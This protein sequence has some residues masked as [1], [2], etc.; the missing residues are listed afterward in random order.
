MAALSTNQYTRVYSDGQCERV[1]LYAVKKASAGDTA[2]VSADFS[3]VIRAGYVSMAGT[4]I[5][6]CTV[7]SNTILTIPTGPANDA[8]VMVVVGVA[9]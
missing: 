5:N 8:A 7:T 1:A 3:F 4:T 6:T 9:S 2:D